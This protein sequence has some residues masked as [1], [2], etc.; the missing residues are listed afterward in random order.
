MAI[1][2]VPAL[3]GLMILRVVVGLKDVPP[4]RGNKVGFVVIIVGF[5]Y[6]IVVE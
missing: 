2:V 6:V 3:I 4:V 1:L 5:G